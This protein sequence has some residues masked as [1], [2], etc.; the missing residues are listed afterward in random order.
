MI[1]AVGGL[2]WFLVP[3][4][5]RFFLSPMKETGYIL[6]AATHLSSGGLLIG[7]ARATHQSRQDGAIGY[8]EKHITLGGEY[9]GMGKPDAFAAT[10][11][12][13]LAD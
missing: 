3:R 1:S 13:V 9:G 6:A 10:L 2:G 4:G 7:Y 12:K 11:Y 8:H 5:H